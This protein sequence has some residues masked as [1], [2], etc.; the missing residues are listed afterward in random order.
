MEYILA[1]RN[2]I[3]YSIWLATW[4]NANLW[5]KWPANILVWW[6]NITDQLSVTVLMLYVSRKPGLMWWINWLELFWPYA[7]C[8]LVGAMMMINAMCFLI[9]DG[10]FFKLGV[11]RCDFLRWKNSWCSAVN[12]SSD[13]CQIIPRRANT[14]ANNKYKMLIQIQTQFK[15]MMQIQKQKQ[16]Q[17][18]YKCKRK[19]KQKS[20]SQTKMLCKSWYQ[21][22]IKK[23]QKLW[24]LLKA[25]NKLKSEQFSDTELKFNSDIQNSKVSTYLLCQ[26]FC[27]KSNYWVQTQ[28]GNNER[29]QIRFPRV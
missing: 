16:K 29:V 27:E 6:L 20:K 18:K 26:N 22:V 2:G 3:K 15:M 4:Y 9:L 7:S 12:F 5:I 28:L 17:N 1:F 14:N 11:L 23:E 8:Y 25:K 21:N 10:F 24:Y 19:H 13:I